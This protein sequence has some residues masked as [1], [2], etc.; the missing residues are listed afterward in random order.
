MEHIA[1]EYVAIQEMTI[2]HEKNSSHKKESTKDSDNI[3]HNIFKC[4]PH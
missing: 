4:Q 1:E 2:S 3:S